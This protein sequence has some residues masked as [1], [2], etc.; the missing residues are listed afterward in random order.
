MTTSW[1]ARRANG[2]CA[3]SP[4]YEHAGAEVRVVVGGTDVG[5]T[6]VG[7]A[8]DVGGAVTAPVPDPVV[9]GLAEDRAPE[10]LQAVADSA[11]TT[12]MANRPC[13]IDER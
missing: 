7:V 3:T 8:A 5:G 11:T 1:A 4:A 9:P 2:H 10:L 13:T 12:M 6:E